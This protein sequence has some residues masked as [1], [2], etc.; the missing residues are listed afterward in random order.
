MK[1]A[2]AAIMLSASLRLCFAPIAPACC[3]S[4]LSRFMIEQIERNAPMFVASSTVRLGVA[5]KLPYCNR[6][7][8]QWQSSL[9]RT[10]DIRAD[11]FIL[12]E[13]VDD[14]VRVERIHGKSFIS[15]FFRVLDELQREF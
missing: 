3:A 5:K 4:A 9:K 2:V 10:I 15:P 1:S 14:C 13:I 11:N 7:G 12:S 6:G 8:I